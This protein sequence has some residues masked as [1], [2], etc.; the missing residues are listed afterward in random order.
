MELRDRY[1]GALL[2]GGTRP[3]LRCQGKILLVMHN[4]S[5]AAGMSSFPEAAPVVISHT[6]S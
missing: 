5:R 6:P 2:W 1:R 3:F 4:A